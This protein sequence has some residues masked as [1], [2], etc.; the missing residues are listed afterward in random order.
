MSTATDAHPARVPS[1]AAASVTSTAGLLVTVRYF[2]AA[3][4]AAGVAEE[5]LA[6]EPPASA[7]LATVLDLARAAHGAEFGRVLQR[8]SY[9]VREVAVHDLSAPLAQGDSIDVLPP[10][11][12]G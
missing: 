9:L 3:K 10:F 6:I 4:A 2:G 12:G 7:I 8:C 5:S 11:A 1:T